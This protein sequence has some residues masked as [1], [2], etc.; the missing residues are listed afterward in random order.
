MLVNVTFILS[1]PVLLLL[2]VS[3]P[4]FHY[5]GHVFHFPLC[6]DVAPIVILNQNLLHVQAIFL[7][8]MAKQAICSWLCVHPSCISRVV[9]H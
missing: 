1:L 9:L 4:I 7:H 5:L 2:H 8:S 3:L 6:K